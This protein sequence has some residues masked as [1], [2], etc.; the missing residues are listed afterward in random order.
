M[1]KAIEQAL[2]LVPILKPKTIDP[3][4]QRRN[5]I[6]K[7]IKRQ[8][9]LVEMFKIGEKTHRAWFWMNEGGQIL[10]HI[11]YGK[12]TLELS[13][14]KFA[15]QCS[16][17]DDVTHNLGVIETLICKGEFDAMLGKVSQDIRSKFLKA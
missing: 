10:L 15:V 12:V 3:V 16:S 5:R 7:S 17:M 14:G 13:K 8:K 2:V 4:V 6:L 1:S 11:K 9:Q